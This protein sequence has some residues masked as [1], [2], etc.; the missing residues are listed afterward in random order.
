MAVR[1]ALGASRGRIARQLLTESVTLALAGGALGIALALSAFSLLKLALPADTA[2]LSN[3]HMGWEAMLFA[4][5]L[6]LLT[7]LAFGLAPALSASRHDLA[8]TIK[9]G[10]QRAAGTARARMRSALIMGEVA[11]AVVLAVGAGLLIKSLWMLARVNPGFEPEHILTLRVSPNQSV[12]RDRAACIAL[13]HELVRRTAEIPGVH[14]VAAANTI[15]M[16]AD[17]PSIPVAVEGHPYVPGHTMWPM[18]W[19]GAVTP[20]YFHLMQIPILAGRGFA[21]SDGEKSAPVVIVSAAMARRYW[22]GQNPIGKHI[23]PVF[24]ANWRTVIGVAGDVRQYD[25][26]NHSP[27]Y[28]RGAMYMPY[29]QSVTNERQLPAAMT[30]IVRTGGDPTALPGRIRGLVRDL[31]P[32]V[33]VSEIRTLESLV[34]A[35]T[36]QSRSMTWLFI[37]FAGAA[38]LLAAI[39]TYGVV[40]YSTAQRTFEI[41]MRAALGASRR[42][43][44]GLVLGQSLRL[45]ITGLIVGIIASVILTRMLAAFLYGTAAT[46]PMT[47]LAVC[48]VLVT[49][50]LVAGYVPARRA[51]SID[52]STALRVE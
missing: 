46:D 48:G 5:L 26:A 9:M 27:D 15:P 41:G 4:S 51:A 38:L 3:A 11:V 44:F 52:P 37:T 20:L 39:G 40:S 32:D 13:F 36:Q 6:S 2:G 42:N 8:G 14:G 18:F 45:A 31:N 24:E 16:A 25:L 23:R 50:A 7:G 12:C 33:P 47:F 22:L 19:A 28:I 21:D 30:L 43:I 29:P 35:S 17:V 10:G 1:A 49:V 34:D